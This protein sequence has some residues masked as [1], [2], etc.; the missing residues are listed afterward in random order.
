MSVS[1]A[2]NAAIHAAADKSGVVPQKAAQEFR[3]NTR[4][5]ADAKGSC[6]KA[7]SKPLPKP[8]LLRMGR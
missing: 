8:R 7:A 3:G 5:Q 1:K 6:P 4:R 2:Q